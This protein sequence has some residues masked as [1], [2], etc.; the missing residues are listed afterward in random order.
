[1]TAAFL[2]ILKEDLHHFIS[3]SED[4]SCD[5]GTMLGSNKHYN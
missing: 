2:F 4:V 3:I 1:M 5:N